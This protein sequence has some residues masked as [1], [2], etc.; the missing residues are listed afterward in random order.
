MHYYLELIAFLGSDKYM[1]RLLQCALEYFL[2]FDF[3]SAVQTAMFGTYSDS[4]KKRIIFQMFFFFFPLKH[5]GTH[6]RI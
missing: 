3:L 2:A 1:H 6:S 4:F 5:F